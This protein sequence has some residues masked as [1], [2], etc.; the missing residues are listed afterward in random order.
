MD[1]GKDPLL[2]P[3]TYTTS[4]SIGS[5]LLQ[6]QYYQRCESVTLKTWVKSKFVLWQLHYYNWLK[7]M[8]RKLT[9]LK[10]SFFENALLLSI[11]RNSLQTPSL[12]DILLGNFTLTNSVIS[13]KNL[14]TW[15][16]GFEIFLIKQF[17]GDIGNKNITG[18]Y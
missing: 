2:L 1:R 13:V 7:K 4:S 14:I 17:A 10:Y 16:R 3:Y 8:I 18:K 5:Y 15:K 6:L 11:S 9:F 12:G